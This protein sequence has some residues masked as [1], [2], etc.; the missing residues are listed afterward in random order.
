MLTPA[1]YLTDGDYFGE[2]P[3][4]PQMD[5]A[6]S[7]LSSI[8]QLFS[9]EGELSPTQTVA[10]TYTALLAAE[11][12]ND[13]ITHNARRHNLVE[14]T[15]LLHGLNLL[16]AHLTQTIQKLAE[17]ADKRTFDGLADLTAAA[18]KTVLDSLCAAGASGEVCAGHLKEAHLTLRTAA[19]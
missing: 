3:T 12:I 13:V 10:A 18:V 2:L 9:D 11:H 17:H 7:A 19:K 16:H 14:L 1:W 6:E 4:V 8:S 15:R 5:T